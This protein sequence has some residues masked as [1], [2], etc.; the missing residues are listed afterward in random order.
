MKKLQFLV[1]FLA[2]MLMGFSASLRAEDVDIYVDNA[3]TNGVP[4][5]LFVMD[6]GANFS[7]SAAVPCTAYASGGAPSLGDTAG[8]VEQC[9]LVDSIS[10]LPNGSVNI[11]IIVNNNNGFATDVRSP[12][13]AAYHEA[14]EGTYGGCLV[15]KFTLM[16]AAGKASL[17]NFIKSWKTSGQ[18]SA[19]EFNVKSGGDRTANMMQEAWAYFNGKIGMSGKNYGSSVLGAGCQRNFI[20]F[21][22][23]AFNTSGTPGDGGSESP[24]DGTNAMT[25]GQ[26]GASAAQKL[27]ITNRMNFSPA[28]CGTT[29]IVAGSSASDWSQNWAD[30]WARLMYQQDGGALSSEGA[31]NIITYTIGVVNDSSCKPDYPAL[32]QSM[33]LNGGGKYFKTSTSVDVKLALDTI[34]NE[35]QAVNSVFSSASLPVSVRH[36]RVC[37]TS[38]VRNASAPSLTP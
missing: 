3:A 30:E 17:V 1:L 38:P 13:D 32:L 11:G 27:K 4:N 14:C 15:R 31:Q 35:V 12:A 10:A 5:V 33:A 19:T 2:A 20:I 21:I 9:A 28:T 24:F 36:R 18:N 22:G 29:S 8:G 23:N 26:V 25:S 34:L 37:R 6:T 7:S 16:D